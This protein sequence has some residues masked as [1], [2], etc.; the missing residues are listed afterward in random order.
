MNRSL[1]TRRGTATD[2][3]ARLVKLA[4]RELKETRKEERLT[5]K[6]SEDF[7]E[8]KVEPAVDEED[9]GRQCGSKGRDPGG[10][11]PPDFVCKLYKMVTELDDKVLKWEEGKLT[12]S[13]N[14]KQFANV[15]PKYFRHDNFASFQRQ[16]NN[17]GFYKLMNESSATMI[18]FC[19][20]DLRGTAPEAILLLRRKAGERAS[21]ASDQ[22]R[23]KQSLH[24]PQGSPTQSSPTQPWHQMP[25]PPLEQPRHSKRGRDQSH[26]GGR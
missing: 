22:D 16:L 12:V 23:P 6:P 13:G 5:V 4:E 10:S 26:L 18:V 19:R 2:A 24:W 17:F 25:H 14:V 3:M 11:K 15:L 20:E 21:L 7:V 1:R 9:V 8:K